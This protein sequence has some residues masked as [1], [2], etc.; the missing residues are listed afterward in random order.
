RTFAPCPGGGWRLGRSP[1]SS[2]RPVARAPRSAP[3]PYRSHSCAKSSSGSPRGSSWW[4]M[5]EQIA[6]NEVAVVVPTHERPDLLQR[7]LA[8]LIAQRPTPPSIIV[9]DDGAHHLGAA[10]ARNTGWR[11][12]TNAS[13]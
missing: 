10:A 2:A 13:L 9:V 1:T 11:A 8:S 5:T 7:T 6:P 4:P 12:A 3:E